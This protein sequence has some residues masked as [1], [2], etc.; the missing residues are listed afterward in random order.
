MDSPTP[1]ALSFGLRLRFTPF[2]WVLTGVDAKFQLFSFIGQ[3]REPCSNEE[4]V[5]EIVVGESEHDC[6]GMDGGQGVSSRE[7]VRLLQ[8]YTAAPLV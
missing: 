8:N 2:H 3:Y 6:R 5:L 4:T 1:G 7:F